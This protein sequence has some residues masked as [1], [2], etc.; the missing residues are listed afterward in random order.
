MLFRSVTSEVFRT[1]DAQLLEDFARNKGIGMLA[2]WSASRDNPGTLGQ[3]SETTS[4]L[5]DPA[6]SFSRIFNN[7]GRDPFTGLST[8]ATS[9]SSG[10]STGSGSG[11]STGGTTGSGSSGSTSS[12]VVVA[13]TTTTLQA[14]AA[15]AERFQ[16]NY[17]WG[18][19][20]TINGFNPGPDQLDLLGFW[21]EGKIGRAHV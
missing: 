2:M 15:V 18:R 11:G 7:Y 12:T 1:S 17:S 10:G 3:V 9:G 8:T 6:G 20:L 14:D 19:Q 4:G 16:L 21:G 5:S 13:S